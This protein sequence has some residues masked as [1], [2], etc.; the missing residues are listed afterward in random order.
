MNAHQTPILDRLC[1][2]GLVPVVR[3]RSRDVAHTA[4]DLLRQAGFGT[5]E[6]TM[7]VP[8]ATE[9]LRELS[10]STD[11]LL[12]A[13]TVLDL[14]QAKESIR[15]GA[16]YIVSPCIV[17]GLA[18]LCR[19]AGVPCILAGLTPTE[20]LAAWEQGS[21]A[22]KVFPAKSV[23]GPDYIRSIRAV[24]PFIPL[25]PTGGVNLEN[26]GAF[27]RAGAAFVGA[28]SDLVNE[29]A[30]REDPAAVVELGRKY[31]EAV[32]DARKDG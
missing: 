30:V 3:T 21:S 7:T 18:D 27:L 22:V 14:E 31:L 4:V 26:V 16:H 12:G 6:I 23:G 10:R 28:G 9:L 29:Q 13:G 1:D 25:V 5:V 2:I 32:K 20:I 11:M 8:G 15:A 17:E 24:Y 19:A